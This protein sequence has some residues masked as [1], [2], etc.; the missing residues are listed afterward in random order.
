MVLHS[1]DFLWGFS[2]ISLALY[3]FNN[4]SKHSFLSLLTSSS[5]SSSSSSP[6]SWVQ[7]LLPPQDSSSSADE[8]T[9]H[10]EQEQQEEE[11]MMVNSHKDC[12]KKEKG[13]LLPPHPHQSGGN[14]NKLTIMKKKKKIRPSN[15][16]VPIQSYPCAKSEFEE[17]CKRSESKELEVRGRNFCLA[18][19]KGRREVM[20]DGYE[21]V[22]DI[23][24]DS[25]QGFFA[26]VDGHGGRAAM[27]YV[28][29]NLG[30][31]IVEAM[32]GGEVVVE[33]AIR[34]GYLV[35]D[36]GFLSQRVSSGA[37][38]AS[39]VMKNG[40]MHV[41]NVGDCRVILSKHG[42]A[43][44]LTIDHRL[45]TR[46]DERRRIENMGGYVHCD[47]VQGSLAVSRA[48]GDLHLKEW[49]ISEPDISKV[50][51][52]PDCQFLI[53][54]SDGLWD[55]VGEQ[56]AVDEVS[57]HYCNNNGV[58]MEACKKLVQLSFSRGNLD[59][60]TVMV[61]SLGSFMDQQPPILSN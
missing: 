3:L 49:V 61:I 36:K 56:E 22:T 25:K 59:D 46:E 40:A 9:H 51:I 34:K 7:R 12:G 32:D 44:P 24:G 8:N 50:P 42:V 43:V 14:N 38:V 17:L 60:A 20:E 39:V 47:R 28:A 21:V 2:V 27:E 33:E 30:K 10:Q 18:S 52:T 16:I 41:A 13:L 6:L 53:M 35:T 29:E 58:L 55:K 11:I 4:I 54:A 19:K 57:R 31:N 26:V 37:C 23:H 5:S 15:L 48:I 1:E 45:N